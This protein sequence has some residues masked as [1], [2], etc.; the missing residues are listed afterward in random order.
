MQHIDCSW[1]QRIPNDS[2]LERQFLMV[3]PAIILQSRPAQTTCMSKDDNNS[4]LLFN[5]Q[6]EQRNAEYWKNN[7]ISTK[8]KGIDT[9]GHSKPRSYKKILEEHPDKPWLNG[10]TINI[11][12]E[13]KLYSLNYYNPKDCISTEAR[14]DLTA[15]SRLSDEVMLRNMQHNSARMNDNGKLWNIQTSALMSEHYCKGGYIS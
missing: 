5:K 8:A 7:V 1:D 14:R 3:R 4:W 6:S 11:D 12:N 9:V 2:I 15:M 10:T 13:S